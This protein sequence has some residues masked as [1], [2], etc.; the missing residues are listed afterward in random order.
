[1]ILYKTPL[2]I[3]YD[4]KIMN[5]TYQLNLSFIKKLKA[6]KSDYLTFIPNLCN[7]G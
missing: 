2:Y 7:T 1:M 5:Q 4:Y 6:S 3:K